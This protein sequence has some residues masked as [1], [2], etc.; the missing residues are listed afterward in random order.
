MNTINIVK[1]E[2]KSFLPEP[3]LPDRKELVSLYWKA[4]D[5]LV[6]NIRHGQTNNGFSNSFVDAAFSENIFQWDSCFISQF[7]RYGFKCLPVLPSLDNFYEKQESDGY[8][9]REYC[10]NNGAALFAKGS[11]DAVNPPIFAWS[12]LNYFKL[13]NDRKRLQKVLPILIAYYQWIEGN[14]RNDNML[15][16]SSPLGC[17]MDNTPRYAASW[18]DFSSQQALNALSISRIAEAIEDEYNSKLYLQKY[19]EL[20][21]LIN[22]LMWDKKAGYYWDLDTRNSFVPVKTI[23]PFWTL[24]SETAYPDRAKI[25]T[26]H[27]RNPAEFWRP[28]VFPTLSADNSLYNPR[29]GYWRGGVWS[30]TTYAVIKGLSCY[31][32]WALARKAS[33]NH[34][35]NMLQVFN[36]T[37][38]IWENYSPESSEPGNI[39]KRDFVGFSGVG[40]I[41]LLIEE[42]LGFDV[43]APE[44]T[45]TWRLYPTEVHGIKNL[46][47]GDNKVSLLAQREHEEVYHLEINAKKNFTLITFIGEVKEIHII[48]AGIS[49]ITIG[50]GLN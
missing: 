14:R 12:E 5:L 27:L 7:A 9:C 11:A 32:E 48:P 15:Y 29:G 25:L 33:E 23:A 50:S 26:E 39:A 1:L 45:I 19:N 36:D 31:G 18:I 24:L 49:N 10:G 13:T 4:F 28:H 42:V 21:R 8:I 30:P 34:L 3:V 2:I 37:G 16:W 17:G 40:P 35:E 38:T 22:E 41:S 47:F 43:D 44:N 20:K 6:G 46:Y